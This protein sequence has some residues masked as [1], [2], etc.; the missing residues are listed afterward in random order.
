MRILVTGHLGY[1]GSVL[2]KILEDQGYKV[3]GLDVGFYQENTVVDISQSIKN[4]NLDLR[5]ITH[6][7]IDGYDAIIHLA[8]LSHDPLGEFNPRL[9]KEIN[10]N[11]TINLA[12]IAK[13]VGVKRFIYAS[14]QSIYGISNTSQ[15]LDEYNSIKNPIS[16]YA[17]NKWIS[18]QEIMKL[19]DDNFTVCAFR[20]STV[21]GPSPRFRSDIVYNN[22]MSC[23]LTTGSIEIY[24]DGTPCRPIVHI[25]DVCN[26][27]ISGLVA[28]KN[29]INSQAF[30]VGIHNGNYTVKDI[31]KAAQS[32]VPGSD[33][34]FTNKYGKDERTYKVS[35]NR[36]LTV[37]KDFYKPKWNIEN[38]G[39]QLLKFLK[40]INIT[41]EI[42]RGRQ[43]VRLKQLKHLTKNSIINEELR[44]NV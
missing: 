41:E 11:S 12:K 15:E 22:L 3:T 39:D 17:I 43:T 28:P 40:D 27:F 36:I 20:P 32:R 25:D 13:K 44:F 26:A 8:S 31:A 34:I 33:L 6:E 19:S 42:F 5:S 18:E 16:A 35:F 24:S 9:T 10:C 29:L 21:F 23:A 37:L 4:L 14:T 1:I 30:N 38:G 2:T 7:I